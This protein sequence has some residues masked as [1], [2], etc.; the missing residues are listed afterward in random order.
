M[1]LRPRPGQGQPPWMWNRLRDNR[2]SAHRAASAKTHI[3]LLSPLLKAEGELL[4]PRGNIFEGGIV[5][6][7]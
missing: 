1:Y 3:G 2:I 6:V 4:E 5:R 7:I